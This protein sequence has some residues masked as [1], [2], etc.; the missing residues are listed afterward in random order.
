MV[1]RASSAPGGPVIKP[2]LWTIHS[3]ATN[4]PGARRSRSGSRSPALEE[5]EHRAQAEQHPQ[6]ARVHED[7]DTSVEKSKQSELTANANGPRPARHT[8]QRSAGEAGHQE[9][10]RG[11]S[12]LIFDLGDRVRVE[13]AARYSQGDGRQR[14]KRPQEDTWYEPRERLDARRGSRSR[15]SSSSQ[16]RGLSW[17]SKHGRVRSWCAGP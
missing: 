9:D 14:R 2:K 4:R 16:R 5:P 17:Y 3:N 6:R 15:M 11:E 8:P 7:V 12:Q 1:G 10:Q 13:S